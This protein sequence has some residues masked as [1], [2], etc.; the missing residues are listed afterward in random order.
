[1]TEMKPQ[2]QPI[3][4]NCGPFNKISL[5][6]MIVEITNSKKPSKRFS[7]RLGNGKT[8]YFGL[9]NGSTYIDHRDK[10]MRANYRK[11]NLAN[12]IE[13]RLISELIPS[14]ALFSAML[15]WGDSTSLSKNI[16]NLNHLLC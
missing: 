3:N 11:M 6:C 9:K 15:L 8:F 7:I 10:R 4:T 14:P 5:I 16:Q 1:M 12:R 2:H 13:Y